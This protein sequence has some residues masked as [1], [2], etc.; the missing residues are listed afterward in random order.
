MIFY[1]IF[2]MRRVVR[3]QY[4]KIIFRQSLGSL[5]KIACLL[6][7]DALVLDTDDLDAVV[8]F[9]ESYISVHHQFKIDLIM[10]NRDC[11]KIYR[12]E[13]P[14]YPDRIFAVIVISKHRKQTI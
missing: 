2:P 5:D 8:A 12:Y 14:R 11:F 13:P 4:F 10:Q 3:Q 9:S 1:L 6:E 7:S